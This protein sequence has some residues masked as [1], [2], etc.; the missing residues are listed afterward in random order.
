[1]ARGVI[2]DK[3]LDR[4]TELKYLRSAVT[5]DRGDIEGSCEKDSGRLRSM[6]ENNR[7]LGQQEHTT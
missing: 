2:E 3:K 6:E 5:I 1:M 7:Y 4:L